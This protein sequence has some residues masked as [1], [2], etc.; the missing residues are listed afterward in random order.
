LFLCERILSLPILYQIVHYFHHDIDQA[1]PCSK[2]RK[3]VHTGQGEQINEKLTY[4][5]DAVR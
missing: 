4:M 5:D 1:A 2:K 3:K